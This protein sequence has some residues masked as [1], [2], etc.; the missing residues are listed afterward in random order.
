MT[1]ATIDGSAI[2][3]IK[4]TEK[5]LELGNDFKGAV[6][7][8][9]RKLLNQALGVCNDVYI[10]HFPELSKDSDAYKTIAKAMGEDKLKN[11]QINKENYKPF[12]KAA[13]QKLKKESNN[14]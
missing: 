11:L 1:A 6:T 4:G 7:E 9:L 5:H 14:E 8:A 2:K 12:Y 3:K 13:Y 10:A